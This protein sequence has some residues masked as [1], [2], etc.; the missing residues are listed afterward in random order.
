MV[1]RNT[2]A[3]NLAAAG[4]LTESQ[5]QMPD[6]QFQPEMAKFPLGVTDYLGVGDRYDG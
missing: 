4:P 5:A 1:T 2:V 3:G 6:V